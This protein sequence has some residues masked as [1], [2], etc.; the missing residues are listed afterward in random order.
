MENDFAPPDPPQQTP[1][2][3]PR[4]TLIRYSV[5]AALGCAALCMVFII[6]YI[7]SYSLD[8]TL[9]F[10]RHFDSYASGNTANLPTVLGFHTAQN[11]MFQQSCGMV[12]GLFFAFVGL[13]LFLVGIQGTLDANGQVRDYAASA[14]RLIPGGVILVASMIFVGVSAMRPI[15]FVLGPVAPA[16]TIIAPTATTVAPVAP[17]QSAP[18][19]NTQ[20]QLQPAPPPAAHLAPQS[21]QV[22]PTTQAPVQAKPLTASQPTVPS[23]APILTTAPAH[24]PAPRPALV[25][26]AAATPPPPQHRFQP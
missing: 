7:F 2:A 24:H 12:A 14:K 25:K 26:Q 16:A 21:A 4:D 9:S 10:E 17:I 8:S 3:P 6:L 18:A 20:S 23:P 19:T 11:R 1:S 5:F 15:D 13:A 22:P